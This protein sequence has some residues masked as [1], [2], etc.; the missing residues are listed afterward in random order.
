VHF[1]ILRGGRDVKN[2]NVKGSEHQKFFKD[3]QNVK[4]SEP[5]KSEHQKERQKS[6]LS[7]FQI[8]MKCQ[9]PMA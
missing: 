2:Q 1:V 8:L 3:D 6:T 5:Q 9:L 7:D 4:R